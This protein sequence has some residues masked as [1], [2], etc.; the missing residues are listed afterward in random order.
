[1]L[2]AAEQAVDRLAERLALQVP[3]S[4][5]DRGHRGDADRR[6]AEVHRAAI[7]LL[8]EPFV[9]E[10]VLADQKSPQP[11]GDVVAERGVDDRLHH[12]GRRIR[13]ADAFEAVVGADADEHRVLAAGGLRLDVRDA[14]N[15]ADDL[16]DLHR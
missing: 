14:E 8:P 10:R 2:L 11:A 13:L 9:V 12:L 7:H 1:M 15:L 6:A 3:Q 5:I 16:G 4:H